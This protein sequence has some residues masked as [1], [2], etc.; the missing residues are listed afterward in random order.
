MASSK[1]GCAFLQRDADHVQRAVAVGLVL[2]DGQQPHV[3]RH[4][5]ADQLQ[6]AAQVAQVD[7]S[8]SGS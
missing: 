1:V 4:I 5:A 6:V 2:D 8:P 3:F 7:F